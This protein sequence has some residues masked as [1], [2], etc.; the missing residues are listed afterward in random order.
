[1]HVNVDVQNTHAEKC[2]LIQKIDINKM[3]TQ[4]KKLLL[5]GGISVYNLYTEDKIFIGK[6][7]LLHTV[8][9]NWVILCAVVLRLIPNS[10]NLRQ[11]LHQRDQTAGRALG[12]VSRKRMTFLCLA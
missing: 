4:T 12:G 3:T 8:H 2:T 10:L 11:I 9:T 1:M 7:L 6:R 5:T